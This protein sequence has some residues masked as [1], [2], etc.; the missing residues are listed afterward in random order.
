MTTNL[1]MSDQ[2]NELA[3]ALSKAQFAIQNVSKDKQA[4]G[5]KYADLASCLD[6][7]KKPLADNFLSISQIFSY[8]EGRKP[9][10]ITMLLHKSGQWLKSFFP[11]EPVAVKGSNDLQQLGAGI[12]YVRRYALAAII[13]LSQEDNDARK[14]KEVTEVK[15]EPIAKLLNLCKE[16]R[17]D[18]KKFAAFHGVVSSDPLTVKNAVDNFE[19]LKNTF[20]ESKTNSVDINIISNT[21][22][23][24]LNAIV[25][26]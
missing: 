1:M 4:F 16:N 2:L 17:V 21:N 3:E 19:L 23:E 8:D 22:N 26:N 25:N 6:A 15:D 18:A 9:I 12:S 11:I 7:I 13:G 20:N 14:I 5:Y 24:V 10:L